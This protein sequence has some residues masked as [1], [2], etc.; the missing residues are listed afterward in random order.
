[1]TTMNDRLVKLED[2][3]VN[4]VQILKQIVETQNTMMGMVKQVV[5]TQERIVETQQTIISALNR[6]SGDLELIKQYLG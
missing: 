3:Y 6:Q 2:A 1:M 4:T 5:E